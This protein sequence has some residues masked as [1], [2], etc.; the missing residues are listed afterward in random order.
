MAK[1]EIYEDYKQSSGD[2]QGR[3]V[4]MGLIER[5]RNRELQEL[6]NLELMIHDGQH[7]ERPSQ[8]KRPHGFA[9]SVHNLNRVAAPDEEEENKEG[10]PRN[11]KRS[12]PESEKKKE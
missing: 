11:K 10:Q 9:D 12:L 7:Q 2:K 6:K 1:K 8:D 3:N 4:G 5:E